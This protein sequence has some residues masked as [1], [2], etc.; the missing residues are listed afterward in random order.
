MKRNL[1]LLAIVV[2][3]AAC[4][5]QR[6]AVTAGAG[7]TRTVPVAS[8]D[9]NTYLLQAVSTDKTYAYTKTNPVKVGGVQDSAGP[10]N[11]HRFLNALLGPQGEEI[12][13]YRAGSCC[14]FKTPNGMID[15]SGMLDHYRITWAGAKD[16]LDVYINMYDK[17]DLS[18]PV[19]LTAKK[20]S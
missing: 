15:N 7:D 1:F 18:V 2:A 17:G 16:T 6:S 19:G 8:I 3:A 10:K 20:K 9:D 11:E 12:K 14:G 4:A 13:Y 5:S